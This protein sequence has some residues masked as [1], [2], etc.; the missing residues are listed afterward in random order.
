MQALEEGE[1]E[2]GGK[3]QSTSDRA[4]F[5]VHYA[6]YRVANYTKS[7][8][9]DMSA[10]VQQSQKFPETIQIIANLQSAH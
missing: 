3:S 2:W 7:Y 1:L 8:Q 9:V 4:N 5:V 6:H 10:S